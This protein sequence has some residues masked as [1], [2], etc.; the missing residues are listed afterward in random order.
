MTNDTV[1]C[2][3]PCCCLN[4]GL[5]LYGPPPR[6]EFCP[7]FASKMGTYVSRKVSLATQFLC[8]YV[9]RMYWDGQNG[10]ESKD[11]PKTP[12]TMGF[13]MAEQY[14]LRLATSVIVAWVLGGLHRR[15][16]QIEDKS[17][18]KLSFR[19]Y[20]QRHV[21]EQLKNFAP[22]ATIEMGV[23]CINSLCL[24]EFLPDCGV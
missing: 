4:P 2:L 10:G 23:A 13:L 1:C 5:S 17:K 20:L 14:L 18:T 21:S 15:V 22:P 7:R 3:I 11:S 8:T 24:C 9:C 16:A 19:S 6:T 12:T